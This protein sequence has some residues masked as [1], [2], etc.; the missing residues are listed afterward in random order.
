MEFT[1]AFHISAASFQ[2]SMTWRFSVEVIVTKPPGQRYSSPVELAPAACTISGVGEGL[3]VDVGGGVDVEP[4]SE[5]G[6]TAS[7]LSLPVL[8]RRYAPPT[9]ALSASVRST[10]A[11]KLFGCITS[12]RRRLARGGRCSLTMSI[13]SRNPALKPTAPAAAFRDRCCR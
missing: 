9:A 6:G 10:P 4:I 12:G 11:R 2:N 13:G 3:G 7:S 1:I 8:P 5:A